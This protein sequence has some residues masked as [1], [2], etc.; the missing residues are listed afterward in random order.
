V[1]DWLQHMQGEH[2]IGWYCNSSECHD[3]MFDCQVDFEEHM[4]SLHAETFNPSQLPIISESSRRPAT[5]LFE[6]C[7]LC[8]HVPTVQEL[9]VWKREGTRNNTGENLKILPK[10]IAVHLEELALLS[11]PWQD[12][13]DTAGSSKKTRYRGSKNSDREFI[14]DD[15]SLTFEDPSDAN[16]ISGHEGKTDI[17]IAEPFNTSRESEW[18]FWPLPDYEGHMKDPFLRLLVDGFLRRRIEEADIVLGDVAENQNS[19]GG[20]D[21]D[22][23]SQLDLGTSFGVIKS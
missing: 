4:K 14:L 6:Q 1:G 18:G 7:P 8:D 17:P 22:T 3:Q 16:V 2:N 13:L 23:A 11:L 10:H 9:N 20:F 21:P 5:E 15:I 19:A 12:D